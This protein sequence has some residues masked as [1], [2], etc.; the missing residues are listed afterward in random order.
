MEER[1]D[2][3]I[4][5]A[6]LLPICLTNIKYLNENKYQRVKHSSIITPATAKRTMGIKL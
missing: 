3:A 2:K 6:N 1:I 4:K 5:Y